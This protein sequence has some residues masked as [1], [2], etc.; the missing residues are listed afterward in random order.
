MYVYN[1]NTISTSSN[2]YCFQTSLLWLNVGMVVENVWLRRYYSISLHTLNM[3]IWH[4]IYLLYMLCIYICVYL[5]SGILIDALSVMFY[6]FLFQRNMNYSN[7]NVRKLKHIKAHRWWGMRLNGVTVT[8][9]HIIRYT[10]HIHIF[11]FLYSEHG[12][13]FLVRADKIKR[14]KWPW[15]GC[16]F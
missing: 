14:S 9:I 3:G 12:Q 16:F 4:I 11:I 1:T 7:N 6:E 13:T 5:A 10:Q 15:F 8:H 2:L